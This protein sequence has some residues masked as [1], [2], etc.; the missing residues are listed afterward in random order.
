MSEVNYIIED[1]IDFYNEINNST[2]SYINKEPATCL[3]TNQDLRDDYV[4]LECGHKFNYDAIYKDIYNHK[5]IYNYLE[6]YRLLTHQLRC[7]YCRN[8]QSSLLPSNA[9]FPKVHGVNYIDISLINKSLDSKVIKT[10]LYNIGVCNHYIEKTT[11]FGISQ[12]ELCSEHMVKWLPDDSN[13]YCKKHARLIRAKIKKLNAHKIENKISE[14]K[15][16]IKID[17]NTT[18]N[19]EP[20]YVE[21]TILGIIDLTTKEGCSSILVSGKNKGKHCDK[22]IYKDKMCKRHY[23]LKNK[24]NAK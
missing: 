3:I 14:I 9:L 21:N 5:K 12:V 1:G 17:I 6:R 22:G 8:I 4:R 10:G 24:N 7:P 18:I 15:N 19:D 20:N 11:E 2:N 16:N 13:Y 23:N